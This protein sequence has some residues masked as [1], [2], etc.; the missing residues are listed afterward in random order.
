MYP[1]RLTRQ[2]HIRTALGRLALIATA[3]IGVWAP[4]AARAQRA[5][6]CPRPVP[7]PG[8][9]DPRVQQYIVMFVD[10]ADVDRA[11]ARVAARYGVSPSLIYRGPVRGFAAALDSAALAGLRCDPIVRA[12][13]AG[14]LLCFPA[15]DP[16]IVVVV[17]LATGDSAGATRVSGVVRDGTYADSLRPHWPDPVASRAWYAAL[18]R[19]GTYTVELGV[20]GYYP[21]VRSGIRVDRGPCHV[22]TVRIAATLVPRQAP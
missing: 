18:E 16:G 20:P 1:R 6:T 5:A 9:P 15:P 13:D 21:W 19:P 2:Y 12:I 4:R 14:R 10:S 11:M 3:L 8:T 22:E 7:E 17:N